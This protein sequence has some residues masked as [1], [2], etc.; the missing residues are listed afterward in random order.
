[1]DANIKQMINEINN[2]IIEADEIIIHDHKK[3][4]SMAKKRL[5]C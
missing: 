4:L 3:A 1:M 5:K 2:L